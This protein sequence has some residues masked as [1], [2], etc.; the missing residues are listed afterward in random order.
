MGRDMHRMPSDLRAMSDAWNTQRGLVSWVRSACD[1]LDA[2]LEVL[3]DGWVL[4]LSRGQRTAHVM[5]YHFDLNPS[6]AAMVAGD[7]AA[8]AAVLAAAGVPAVDHALIV[9]PFKL[10]YL[11]GDGIGPRLDRLIQRWGLPLVVKPNTGTGGQGVQPVSDRRQL[12]QAVARQWQQRQDAAVGPWL[13]IDAEQRRVVLDQQVQL[14]YAKRRP[15]VVGNGR[16]TLMDLAAQAVAAGRVVP[17]ALHRLSGDPERAARVPGAGAVVPV[18]QLHNLA[19][20]AV[21]E[22]LPIEADHEP[23]RLALAATAALGLRFAAVDVV[24]VGGRWRVLEVNAGVMLERYA[25]LA[26][27]GEGQARRI[28]AAA[29]GRMLDPR[30]IPDPAS[31]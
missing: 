6:A 26:Q 22:P 2:H 9:Q 19:A 25:R 28:V 8:A 29:V 7:K 30:L 31:E 20:G 27:G 11:G 24:R 17:E 12:E 15:E 23:T 3:C 16:S 1:A 4:R 14:A 10:D 5:G 21:P 18:V 13:D